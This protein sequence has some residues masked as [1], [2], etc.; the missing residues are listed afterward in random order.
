[1]RGWL[2]IL[3]FFGVVVAPFVLKRLYGTDSHDVPSAG[4]LRLVIVTPH[5]ESI[6]REFAEAFSRW[7]QQRYGRPV[8]L[9]Y[10][11]IGGT[12]EIV[13]FFESAKATS[14]DRQGTFRIDLV[15]GGGDFLFDQQLKR[16]GVL[17]PVT[18]RDDVMRYAFPQPA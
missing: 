2:P 7:H 16:A 4:E 12:N 15:W 13:K 9:D 1:M 14:F 5:V 3:L 8:F 10:R 6:R 18:L 17:E 11:L